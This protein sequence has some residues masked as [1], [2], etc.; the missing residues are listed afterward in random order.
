MSFLCNGRRRFM[1]IW[2]RLGDLL[3]CRDRKNKSNACRPMISNP[4][5]ISSTNTPFDPWFLSGVSAPVAEER[6]EAVSVDPTAYKVD[7]RDD[8]AA[9]L[10]AFSR[11]VVILETWGRTPEEH[12]MHVHHLSSP[13]NGDAQSDISGSEDSIYSERSAS[14]ERHAPLSTPSMCFSFARPRGYVTGGQIDEVGK[15][16]NVSI[17]SYRRRRASVVT[18]Q[19]IAEEDE[20]E[21]IHFAE[22]EVIIREWCSKERLGSI[23]EEEEEEDNP[24]SHLSGIMDVVALTLQALRDD[25]SRHLTPTFV[26][27]ESNDDNSSSVL[28]PPGSCLFE[29]VPGSI[30]PPSSFAGQDTASVSYILLEGDFEEELAIIPDTIIRTHRRTNAANIKCPK[31]LDRLDLQQDM[32]TLSSCQSSP[33]T[34]IQRRQSNGKQWLRYH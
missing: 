24:E 10:E 25:S 23:V 17:G 29:E 31:D 13:S 6:S 33:R 22:E 12:D 18:P 1:T 30:T 7:E 28:T 27:D 5:L 19:P 2:S 3:P 8:C 4:Q 15:A 20:S 26:Y 21:I 34:L 11:Q 16:Y 9:D 32:M 14:P